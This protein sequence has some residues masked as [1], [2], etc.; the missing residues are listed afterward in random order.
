M[1]LRVALVGYGRMGKEIDALSESHGCEVT[2]RLDIH[3]NARSES[4]D[5]A[6]L[7]EVDVAIDFSVA[8]ALVENLPKLAALGINVVIGTT[9]WGDQEAAMKKVVADAG[10]GVVVAANFSVGVNVFQGIVE[11][12]AALFSRHEDFGAWI[13]ETHHAGKRDSPSGTAL[14]LETGAQRSGYKAPIDISSTRVGSI[15]GTHTVGFDGPFETIALTHTTRSRATFARGALEA[16]QWLRD[17]RGWF[18]MRD[19][20]ALD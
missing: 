4:I 7:G 5:K 14:A 18:T 19:V 12:A 20:L 2:T 6:T 8:P 15:P 3:N 1:S 17:K 13:H 16:A 11:H 10:I 9:G